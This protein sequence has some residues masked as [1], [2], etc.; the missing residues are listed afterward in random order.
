MELGTKVLS[1]DPL[2][3]LI[4]SYTTGLSPSAMAYIL[5]LSMQ[6]WNGNGTIFAD[7]IGIPVTQTGAILPCGSSAYWMRK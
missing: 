4:N 3:V 6:R 1:D 2:F 7:E 5:H